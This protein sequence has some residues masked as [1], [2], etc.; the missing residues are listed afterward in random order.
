VQTDFE[1]GTDRFGVIAAEAGRLP[2][3]E[4]PSAGLSA[5]RLDRVTPAE[6]DQALG[7]GFGGISTCTHLNDTLRM[8]MDV[9]DLTRDLAASSTG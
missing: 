5:G 7:T 6:L 3:V 1:P 8:L 4:C 9:P 2:W